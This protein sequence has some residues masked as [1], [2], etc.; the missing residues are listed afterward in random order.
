ME[1]ILKRIKFFDQVPNALEFLKTKGAVTVW[2]EGNAESPYEK[3][4]YHVGKVTSACALSKFA[5]LGA[6]VSIL[7]TA[8]NLPILKGDVA[9]S[10]YNLRI[11]ELETWVKGIIGPELTIVDT[12]KE[13][14]LLRSSAKHEN[15]ISFWRKVQDLASIL[16]DEIAKTSQS[17]KDA[18][19]DSL[20]GYSTRDGNWETAWAEVPNIF[21]S[22]IENNL[23]STKTYYNQAL[24]HDVAALLYLLIKNPPW[25]HTGW[26]SQ[27]GAVLSCAFG[28]RL[29][30]EAERNMYWLRAFRLLHCHTSNLTLDKVPFP[31]I[32]SFE[33][34]QNCNGTGPMK[35]DDKEKSICVFSSN[36]NIFEKLNRSCESLLVEM[37]TRLSWANTNVPELKSTAQLNS[38]SSKKELCNGLSEAIYVFRQLWRTYVKN[39]L[40]VD[41]WFCLQYICNDMANIQK[42]KS[43]KEG[44]SPA[45]ADDINSDLSVYNKLA[46]EL[47]PQVIKK[48][49][50]PDIMLLH[51]TVREIVASTANIDVILH[52]TGKRY[53]DHGI[54][55][56]HVAVL[57]HLLLQALTPDSRPNSSRTVAEAV[58]NIYSVKVIDVNAAYIVCSLVHD[59]GYPLSEIAWLIGKL[60][61]MLAVADETNK[62]AAKDLAI[63]LREFVKSF[64]SNW[65]LSLLAKI[66]DQCSCKPL[67]VQRWDKESRTWAEKLSG[68]NNLEW[69]THGLLSAMNLLHLI[70]E[71]KNIKLDEK[72]QP[73]LFQIL[74]AIALHDRNNIVNM[75][76]DFLVFLLALCDEIQEWSRRIFVDGEAIIESRYIRLSGLSSVSDNQWQLSN[77]LLVHFVHS[78]VENTHL[79]WD[80]AR[81]LDSKK[82]NLTRIIN[83]QPNL[84]PTKISFD[85]TIGPEQISS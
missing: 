20:S 56:I 31:A 43:W 79:P 69:P 26:I 6:K 42:N 14:T 45:F 65:Y 57:G 17:Q 61:S 71:T 72:D 16:F 73:L 29:I 63:S 15:I 80:Y 30:L 66:Q 50:H 35:A 28:E 18:L 62:K 76:N 34:L 82:R 48:S 5:A 49:D 55:Q 51:N 47:V 33:N 85:I 27:S 67:S 60:Y 37:A 21:K 40:Q 13:F 8:D 84:F 83:L 75:N 77:N 12:A 10:L 9:K 24:T 46:T 54:H 81:F 36:S 38:S 64:S 74:K 52:M 78:G 68:S 44:L 39:T 7:L 22:I 23:P 32:A 4:R 11:N 70:Q 25:L 1:E 19:K 58:A 41:N 59:T 53:R 2:G 3:S